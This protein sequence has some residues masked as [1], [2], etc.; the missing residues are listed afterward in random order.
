MMQEG[1]Y[2]SWHTISSLTDITEIGL[3]KHLQLSELGR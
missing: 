3:Q 1:K 2:I